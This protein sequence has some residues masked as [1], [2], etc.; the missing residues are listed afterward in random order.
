MNHENAV[1][2]AIFALPL[3]WMIPGAA[4]AQAQSLR[5]NLQVRNVDA[6][7]SC[8][9]TNYRP[10]FKITNFG[11]EP[12]SVGNINIRMFFNNTRQEFIEFVNADFVRIFNA[13]GTI[14]GSFGQVLHF[15]APPP[16]PACVVAPDRRANQTHILALSSASPFADALIPPNGGFATVIVQYRRNGGLFPF[17]T[18]CDDFSK[19]RSTD[20]ARPF[21][22]DRFY[23]LVVPAS[24]TFPS[25]LRCEFT[26]PTTTDPNSGIDAGVVTCGTNACGV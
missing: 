3:M 25:V 24:M 6:T 13:N 7:D 9:S 18:G 12:V 5:L 2:L 23:N 17:D 21:V 20:P 4:S 19:L 26:G 1:R 15:E 10:E 11:T 14:T 16:N 8:N 22:D